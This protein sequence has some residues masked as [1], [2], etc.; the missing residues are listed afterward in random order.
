[1]MGKATEDA[2][3]DLH[4]MFARSLMHKLESGSAMPAELSVIRAFLRDNGIEA[5]RTA[6]DDMDRLAS[7]LARLEAAE[8]DFL[9]S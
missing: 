6:N 7:N 8:G 1:M 2:M 9:H 4:G 5:L 3:A